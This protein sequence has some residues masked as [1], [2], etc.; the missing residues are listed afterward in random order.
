MPF[1]HFHTGDFKYQAKVIFFEKKEKKIK[2]NSRIQKIIINIY[3]AEYFFILIVKV[4][5]FLFFLNG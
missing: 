5:I 2:G 3:E 4:F 1:P